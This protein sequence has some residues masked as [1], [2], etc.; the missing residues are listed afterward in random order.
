MVETAR[1]SHPSLK[2]EV[3]T[4][5]EREVIEALAAG[6]DRIMLDNMDDPTLR[7]MVQLIAGRA[8]TEASGNMNAARIRALADSG[9]DF[10][11]VGAITHSAPVFDFSMLIE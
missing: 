1:K 4:T 8:E 9:L 2:I 5:N 10:V 3:E 7:G 6:A 11:S